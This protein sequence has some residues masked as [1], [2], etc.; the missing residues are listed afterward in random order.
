MSKI[1]QH[2]FVF[3]V[4][5]VSALFNSISDCDETFNYWENMHYLIYGKGFQ[6]WEY[7]P[8][9]AL[10]SYAYILFHILPAWLTFKILNPNSVYLFYYSTRWFLAGLCSVC[11][12][13]FYIGV[14]KEFGP[15][16]GKITLICQLF[17]AGM[18]V[19]STAFLPSSSSMILCMLSHGAW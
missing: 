4:F 7:A 5:S 14:T 8:Q 6:T 9:N 3:S 12:T 17:S 18:F 2:C 19:S 15:N 16:V 1:P 13:Y 10:R 11:E